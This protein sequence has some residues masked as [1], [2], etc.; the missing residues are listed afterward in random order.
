M[1]T[2]G[3]HD[4]RVTIDELA[5]DLLDQSISNGVEATELGEENRPNFYVLHYQGNIHVG[6]RASISVKRLLTYTGALGGAG[7]VIHL[8]LTA[9]SGK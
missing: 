8:I 3:T 6:L 5:G 1:T 9:I 2:A 7:G 4:E